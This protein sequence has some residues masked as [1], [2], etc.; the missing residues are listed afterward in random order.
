MFKTEAFAY[1]IKLTPALIARHPGHKQLS[2]EE[3][4]Q[5]I[6]LALRGVEFAWNETREEELTQQAAER[7]RNN[8]E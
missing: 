2:E 3:I 6:R 7:M 4:C 8:I 5:Y 1:A